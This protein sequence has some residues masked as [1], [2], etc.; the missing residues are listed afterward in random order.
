MKK[1]ST[2]RQHQNERNPVVPFNVVF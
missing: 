1:T 2:T